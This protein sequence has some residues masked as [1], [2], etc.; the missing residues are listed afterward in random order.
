MRRFRTALRERLHLRL[1]DDA[2]AAARTTVEDGLPILA[3]LAAAY[4]ALV[5]LP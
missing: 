2:R 4:A 5:L 1:N 3:I